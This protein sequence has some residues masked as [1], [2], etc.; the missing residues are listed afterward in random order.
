MTKVV[1]S[2]GTS[3]EPVET[4]HHVSRNAQPLPPPPPPPPPQ[5]SRSIRNCDFPQTI[6]RFTPSPLCSATLVKPK[7][8]NYVGTIDEDLV[9][10]GESNSYNY[11]R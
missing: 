9:S 10:S 8:E 11:T 6:H 7:Y 4:H 5:P 2:V 1:T 3:I